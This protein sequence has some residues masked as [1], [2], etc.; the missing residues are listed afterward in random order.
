MAAC[1]ACC[2]DAA[3][4]EKP[5]GRMAELHLANLRTWRQDKYDSSA[6]DRNEIAALEVSL[7]CIA[8]GEDEARVVVNAARQIIVQRM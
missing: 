8:Q 3:I 5:A 4:L 2:L 1:A 7:A 6:F